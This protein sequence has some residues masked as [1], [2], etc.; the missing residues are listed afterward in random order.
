M[1]DT[2]ASR[3]AAWR[4]AD[5]RWALDRVELT[6]GSRALLP[7]VV[8][9]GAVVGDLVAPAL[10]ASGAVAA[11]A[12]VVAGGHDHPTAASIGSAPSSG[13]MSARA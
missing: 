7:E 3:T 5:R 6:L 2:L 12:L 1:S 9:A 10:I 4:A 11:D 13:S 8:P